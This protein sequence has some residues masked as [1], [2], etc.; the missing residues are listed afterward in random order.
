MEELE[1][2]LSV[3]KEIVELIESGNCNI[4]VAEWQLEKVR[5][6]IK[7]LEDKNKR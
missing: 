3:E 1:Y 7:E 4:G 6:A 5:E 2:L